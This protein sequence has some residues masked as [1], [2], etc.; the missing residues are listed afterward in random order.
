M[1]HRRRRGAGSQQAVKTGD[2]VFGGAAKAGIE[3]DLPT[4]ARTD[5]EDGAGRHLD[6]QHLFQTQGLGAKL[7]IVVV[8]APA[9]AALVLDG[10]WLG[11]KLD[12]VSDADKAEA[13]TADPEAANGPV[14]PLL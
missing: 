13:L 8:P 5:M 11:A 10:I 7:H 9:P 12:N 2:G 4:P 6:A 1:W 3:K 14:R